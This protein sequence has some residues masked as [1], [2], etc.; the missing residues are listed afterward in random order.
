MR[1][2]IREQNRKILE[3]A[4]SSGIVFENPDVNFFRKHFDRD[5]DFVFGKKDVQ[6][7]VVG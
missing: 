7:A 4:D 5:I 1:K 2:E 3:F 6:L